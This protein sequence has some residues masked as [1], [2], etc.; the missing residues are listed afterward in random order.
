[1]RYDIFLCDDCCEDCKEH[2]RDCDVHQFWMWPR[3]WERGNAP[4]VP[5]K[6]GQR[7]CYSHGSWAPS[8]QSG[9]DF[10]GCNEAVLVHLEK[11]LNTVTPR[12]LLIFISFTCARHSRPTSDPSRLPPTV[13]YLQFA[14]SAFTSRLR[15]TTV[16]LEFSCYR[17]VSHP[18]WLLWQLN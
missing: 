10:V 16:F 3:S 7:K 9:S 12:F 13:I 14:L 1:M 15:N 5:P 4:A 17:T 2:L 11:R 6:G 18:S 8:R